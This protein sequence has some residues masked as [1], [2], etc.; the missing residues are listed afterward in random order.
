MEILGNLHY[1][2]LNGGVGYLKLD[3]NNTPLISELFNKAETEFNVKLKRGN[4]HISIVRDEAIP[5]TSYWRKHKYP[6]G[7]KIIDDTIYTDGRFYWVDVVCHYVGIIREEL[8]LRRNTDL[9]LHLTLG[10]K[11]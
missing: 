8:G 2:R 4:S 3:C 7:V 11:L 9:P 6:I 1:G 10:H 5:F